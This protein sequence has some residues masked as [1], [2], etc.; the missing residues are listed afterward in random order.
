MVYAEVNWML[1]YAFSIVSMKR[2]NKTK[3]LRKIE[4]KN[5]IRQTTK[6]SALFLFIKYKNKN[7][8]YATRSR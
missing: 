7:K 1:F 8:L 5:V 4:P 2:E 6:Y 3:I